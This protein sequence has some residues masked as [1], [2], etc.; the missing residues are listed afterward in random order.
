MMRGV[1]RAGWDRRYAGDEL[2]WSA[3]PNRF[4][5]AEVAGSPPGRALD[6][7]CGEGRNAVWLAERGWDVTAVDFSQVGLDKGARLAEQRDVSVRWELADL[8]EWT[9]QKAAFDLVVVLYLHVPADARRAIHGAAAQALAPAGVLLVV[10]HDSSNIEHGHGGPQ[11]PAILFAP[12]D[13]AADVPELEIERAE[14]VKRPVETS[15]GEAEAID[16]LLRARRP[17]R[18][19]R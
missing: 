16:A 9:P 17:P 18:G 6:L 2:V 12:G 19:Y 4:L 11:N 8:H 10:G 15:D 14:R 7:A 1:D 3:Q 13:L 5:A